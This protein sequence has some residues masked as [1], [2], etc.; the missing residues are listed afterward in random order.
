[1]EHQKISVVVPSYNQ[2]QFLEQTLRSILD[3]DYPNLEVLVLDGGSTDNSLAIIKQYA[4]RLSFWRSHRDG[5]H[6]AAVAEGL[7]MATGDIC[8]FVN[9]DDMLAN[10]SLHVV[11]RTFAAHPKVNWSIGDTCLIDEHS[12]PYHYLREPYVLKQW[13]IFVRNCIPQPSVF[14]RK[15]FYDQHGSL[16]P[17]LKYCMDPDLFFQFWRV[18]EPM[19]VRQLLSYQR[20]HPA[21]KTATLQHVSA[22]EYPRLLEK[23]FEIS[24]PP[25]TLSKL[26][27]RAHRISVK[28]LRLYYLH[29]V[30]YGVPHGRREL[31][32]LA[33]TGPSPRSKG[34]RVVQQTSG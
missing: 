18:S 34:S 7:S 3:Q 19:M 6:A 22:E 21:T 15:S 9:S 14:W 11:A 12:R 16:N 29:A 26:L 8:A 23:Y 2:G 30:L 31:A 4:R 28:A 24:A 10:G 25:S 1:M 17:S 32:T 5:G 27:W 13:Q 33:R 20:H